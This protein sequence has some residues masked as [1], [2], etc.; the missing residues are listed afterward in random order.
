MPRLWRVS[1]A[2]Q[3]GLCL[4]WSQTPDMAIDNKPMLHFQI[5]SAPM[6]YYQAVDCP[7][8]SMFKALNAVSW[9]SQNRKK[10][11]KGSLSSAVIKDRS[12]KMSRLMTKPTK[13]HVRS[14][15]TQISLGIRPVWS[16][17]SLSAWRKLGSLATYWLCS[18][19][20]DP[21]LICVFA[22]RT[23]ILLVLSWGDSNVV[24]IICSLVTWNEVKWL[25][26]GQKQ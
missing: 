17:S 8:V 16:E 7:L 4:T 19:L 11:M 9:F 21:R 26:N 2:K 13:W 18:D 24:F 1:V 14:T 6:R 3:A 5:I 10:T 23:I 22:G 15:K 12:P 20:A 25:D